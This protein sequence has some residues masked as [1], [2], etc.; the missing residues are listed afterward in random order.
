MGVYRLLGAGLFFY[1]CLRLLLLVFFLHITPLQGGFFTGNFLFGALFPYLVY[2]SS[3]A[4]FPL[5]ILFAW[6]RPGEYRN[7]LTLYMAGKVIAVV[8]FFVWEILSFRVLTG[9]ENAVKSVM[10][11]CM[12]DIL[13]VL[14]ALTLK[15]KYRMES[16]G[17]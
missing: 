4:L 1:E 8:L 9:L 16:G 12:A 2:L 7:Y 10:L 5:M 11:L 6:L 13:S 17:I 15:N 14:G 3:S